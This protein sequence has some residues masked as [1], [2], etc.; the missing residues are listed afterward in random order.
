MSE[1]QA[2]RLAGLIFGSWLG[3]ILLDLAHQILQR[4]SDRPP[5][6]SEHPRSI[7]VRTRQSKRRTSKS[8]FQGPHN[9]EVAASPKC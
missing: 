2:W 3:L 1:L 8:R 9:L 6:P 4:S 5:K 7:K